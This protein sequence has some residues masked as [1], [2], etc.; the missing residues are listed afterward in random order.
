M[1][2]KLFDI[3]MQENVSKLRHNKVVYKPYSTSSEYLLPPSTDDLVPENHIARYLSNVIDSIDISEIE[4]MY[5]GGGAPAYHPRMML[6]VWLLGYLQRIYTSRKLERALRENIVF[7]WISG[8]QRVDFKTLSNFRRNLKDSIESI[9]KEIVKLLLKRGV[10]S[11][12]DVFVDHTKIEANASKYKIVWKKRVEK[13]LDKIEGELERLLKY[14]EEQNEEEDR[15]HAEG[16][17]NIDSK[18]FEQ[19]EMEE[20]I[21]RVQETINKDKAKET[22]DKDKDKELRKV[23]KRVEELKE[24]KARYEEQKKILGD[25]NSYSKTDVEATVMKVKRSKDLAPCYNEGI[26]VENGFVI[27]YNISDNSGDTVSFQELVNEVKE[28][29]GSKPESVVADGGYGSL[30]NYEYLDNEKIEYFVKYSGY[31]KE[32]EFRGRFSLRDFEYNEA[33]NT[34]KCMNDKELEYKGTITR[35]TKRGYSFSKDVYEAREE[36]CLSCPLKAYCT[37]SNKRRL[38]VNEKWELHKKKVRENLR[39]E[40]GRELYRRR[41]SEVERVFAERKFVHGFKRHM[42]RGKAKVKIET[43]LYYI[44]H[45]IKRLYL[46]LQNNFSPPS[47]NLTSC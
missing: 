5:K 17:E 34:Y 21:N 46:L 14:I 10:I 33:S 3:P 45:S 37:T 40:R 32:K 26:A 15:K 8:M 24:R 13:Q 27:G 25:R 11:G 29:L 43:G 31:H 42:L 41:G 2:D 22:T 16:V 12:K 38:E 19:E 44:M 4:K 6:K 1:E 9:F 47:Y 7:M 18:H 23:L 28:N 35:K 20:V 30:E 39:S 36:D